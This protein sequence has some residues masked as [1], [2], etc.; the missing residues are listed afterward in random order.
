MAGNE[1]GMGAGNTL[2]DADGLIE[3]SCNIDLKVA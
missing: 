3:K 2:N 1:I